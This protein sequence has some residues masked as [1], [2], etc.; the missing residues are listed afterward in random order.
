MIPLLYRY[1]SEG[2]YYF[3]DTDDSLAIAT[4]ILAIDAPFSVSMWIKPGALAD[5]VLIGNHILASYGWIVKIRA[6]GT[7]EF[8]VSD[9]GTHW[10]SANAG[11]YTATEWNHVAVT[12]SSA[13]QKDEPLYQ[14]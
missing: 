10:S 12:F 11:S 1:G 13:G 3:D 7:V 4:A 14:G 6:A 9:N 5:E 8:G 2:M